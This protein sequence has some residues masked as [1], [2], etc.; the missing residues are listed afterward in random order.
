[1]TLHILYFTEL[2]SGLLGGH[3]SGVNSGVL[4]RSSSVLLSTR[5][6]VR[7]K[8]KVTRSLTDVW[9][10]LSEQQNIF[11]PWMNEN[12]TSTAEPGDTD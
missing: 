6:V 5:D 3:M 2:R 9:Q 10:Q 7:W 12:H 8:V 4:C 11:H 1:M